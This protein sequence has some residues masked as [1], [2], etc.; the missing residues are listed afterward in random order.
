MRLDAGY[1]YY[2]TLIWRGGEQSNEGMGEDVVAE[3]IG[4][5]DLAQRRR[6]II[7]FF[8]RASVRSNHFTNAANFEFRIGDRVDQISA[9]G[10]D[11]HRPIDACEAAIACIA[12]DGVKVGEVLD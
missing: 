3:D 1:E 12:D 7:G 2:T 6:G 11:C 8:G 4:R 9:Q 5:K 10:P